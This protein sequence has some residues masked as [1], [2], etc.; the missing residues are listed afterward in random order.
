LGA[1]AR[2]LQQL[3]KGDDQHNTSRARERAR[4]AAEACPVRTYNERTM[5]IAQIIEDY[6]AQHPRAADTAE[7]ICSWWVAPRCYGASRE[8]VQ[9]AL[10]YLVEFGRMARVVVAGGA[11]IY[12]GVAVPGQAG[13]G[14]RDNAI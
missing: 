10:D 13:A 2:A 12:A 14:K 9:A 3:P 7:G 6:V 5:M 11:A 8:E 4:V 1:L